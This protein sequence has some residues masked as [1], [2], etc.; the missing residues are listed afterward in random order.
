MTT[1]EWALMPNHEMC[2]IQGNKKLWFNIMPDTMLKIHQQETFFQINVNLS[3]LQLKNLFLTHLNLY[4]ITLTLN[5]LF[6]F[7]QM[8]YLYTLAA[9][10]LCSCFM[11]SR[12]A[13]ILFFR[14]RISCSLVSTVLWCSF[15][16][17]LYLWKINKTHLYVFYTHTNNVPFFSQWYVSIV[18][19]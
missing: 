14:V 7:V 8:L 13:S 18:Y 2:Q 5:H 17:L 15:S 4:I 6:L 11:N 19:Q 10:M 12:L 3:N 16:K 1:T 9:A